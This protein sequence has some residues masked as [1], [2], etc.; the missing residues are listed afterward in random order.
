M[1]KAGKYKIQARVTEAPDYGIV[2]Y[3]LNGKPLGHPMDLFHAGAVVKPKPFLLGRETL[4]AGRNELKVEITGANEKA[5]KRHMFGL[6]YL[7][8]EAE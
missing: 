7:L 6:D 2:Q 8:L 5:E 4:K 1:E 3:H